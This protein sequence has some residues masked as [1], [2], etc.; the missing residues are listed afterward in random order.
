M[1]VA[2]ILNSV[3]IEGIMSHIT[4][5]INFVVVDRVYTLNQHQMHTFRLTQ[6]VHME[7]LSIPFNMG[8]LY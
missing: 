8:E 2:S 3:N 1:N 4:K 6:A 5:D 7:L